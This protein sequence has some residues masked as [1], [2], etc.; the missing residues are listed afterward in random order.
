MSLPGSDHSRAGSLVV[1]SPRNAFRRRP[2]LTDSLAKGLLL[3][4]WYP[5]VCGRDD[6]AFLLPVTLAGI[7]GRQTPREQCALNF[8]WAW[9]WPDICCCYVFIGRLWCAVCPFMI[10]R[11][12]LRNAASL[13]LF[14]RS[15]CRGHPNGSNPLGG[16]GANSAALW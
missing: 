4:R 6:G 7:W 5:K 10:N 2:L 15:S 16:V 14:P 3:S 12:W 8:F 13:W 9:W 11:E 1:Q